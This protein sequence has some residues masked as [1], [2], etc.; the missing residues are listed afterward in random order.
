MEQGRRSHK[1]FLYVLARRGMIFYR[2]SIQQGCQAGTNN[3][4]CEEWQKHQDVWQ[5]KR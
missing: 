4:P 5:F 2:C 3:I 1:R